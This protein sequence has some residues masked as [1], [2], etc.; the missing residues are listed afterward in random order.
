MNDPF[1]EYS[2]GT[3]IFHDVGYDTIFP[4]LHF[5]PAA[6]ILTRVISLP[7]QG[8]VTLDL[9]CKAVA[10]DPLMT[11][12]VVFPQLPDAELVLQNEEHLVIKTTRASK[13]KRERG[14]RQSL[15]LSRCRVTPTAR[16]RQL[17]RS[18][19]T[20]PTQQPQRDSANSAVHSA[21]AP[22]QQPTTRMC[23]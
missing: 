2:P 10:S 22:T 4:D 3:C 12:R 17:G 20:A 6:V 21:T 11:N 14:S 19:A 13:L 18:S 7:G 9:G 1:V 5:T 23:L 8:L 16:Q 15:V